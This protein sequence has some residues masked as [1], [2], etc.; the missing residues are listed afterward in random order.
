VTG[1]QTCALPICSGSKG[2]PS[3]EGGGDPRPTRPKVKIGFSCDLPRVVFVDRK[4]VGE[5]YT[6]KLLDEGTHKARFVE[7][8]GHDGETVEFK[9]EAGKT[10]NVD[11][12]H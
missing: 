4:R 12:A 11:C 8:D 2:E 6:S 7:L 10:K 3:N 5:T 1:V 9:V